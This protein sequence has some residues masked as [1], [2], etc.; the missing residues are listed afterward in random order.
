MSFWPCFWFEVKSKKVGVQ[1]LFTLS[2]CL[3]I[4]VEPLRALTCLAPFH[5]TPCLCSPTQESQQSAPVGPSSAPLIWSWWPPQPLPLAKA[6]LWGGPTP[7][8][9][10]LTIQPLTSQPWMKTWAMTSCQSCPPWWPR[11]ATSLATEDKIWWMM[12]I[13][14][15]FR[16]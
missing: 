1:I 6:P 10:L 3:H 15:S 9:L 2:S 16:L 5:P 4:L 13:I 12:V 14:H 11:T 8:P 7:Q